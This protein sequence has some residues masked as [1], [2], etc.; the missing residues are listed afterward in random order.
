MCLESTC[1]ELLFF[2]VYLCVFSASF[3]GDWLLHKGEPG[4]TQPGRLG[5]FCILGPSYGAQGRMWCPP[6]GTKYCNLCFMGH[7]E[8]FWLP[9]PRLM[10]AAVRHVDFCAF[11]WQHGGLSPPLCRMKWRDVS[12]WLDTELWWAT[13][14][15]SGEEKRCRW[16]SIFSAAELCRQKDG[17]FQPLFQGPGF[18]ER[19]THCAP[20]CM[21]WWWLRNVHWRGLGNLWTRL[22]HSGLS[23]ICNSFYCY[24]SQNDCFK[25]QHFPKPLKAIC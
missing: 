12:C 7:A 17:F 5:S 9:L 10:V 21:V 18:N 22:T 15:Q 19:D 25:S 16:C 3:A 1:L 24:C 20:L 4:G 13:V 11:S 6:T 23:G 14:A 8:L 2:G